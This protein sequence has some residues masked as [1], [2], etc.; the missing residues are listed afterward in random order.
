MK[1]SPGLK[2]EDLL[3]ELKEISSETLLEVVEMKLWNSTLLSPFTFVS[4]NN[5]CNLNKIK[6]ILGVSNIRIKNLK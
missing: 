1:K 3:N 5:E 2:S 6:D 4:L